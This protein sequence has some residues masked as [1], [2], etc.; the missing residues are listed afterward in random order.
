[1]SWPMNSLWRL[2]KVASLRGL[3]GACIFFNS[4]FDP[5]ASSAQCYSIKQI[6]CLIC[7]NGYIFGSYTYVYIECIHVA[8]LVNLQQTLYLVFYHILTFVLRYIFFLQILDSYYTLDM[9]L[10]FAFMDQIKFTQFYIN[11]QHLCRL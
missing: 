6:L 10:M 5:Q 4:R 2:Y 3:K 7:F 9:I 11:Y 1:M 8:G